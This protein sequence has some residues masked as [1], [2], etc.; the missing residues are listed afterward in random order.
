MTLCILNKTKLISITV[1]YSVNVMRLKLFFI[2][3]DTSDKPKRRSYL[4]KVLPRTSKGIFC[5]NKYLVFLIS[6]G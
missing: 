6:I 4:K 3:S 2:F 5:C 1:T